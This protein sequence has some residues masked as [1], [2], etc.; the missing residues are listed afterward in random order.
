MSVSKTNIQGTHT[1]DDLPLSN[2]KTFHGW[3]TRWP[4]NNHKHKPG[5]TGIVITRRKADLR[6]TDTIYQDWYTPKRVYS[7]CIGPGL[8]LKDWGWYKSPWSAWSPGNGGKHISAGPV[9]PAR[10]LCHSIPFLVRK[11]V[12]SAQKWMTTTMSSK[13][14]MTAL[15]LSD[16]FPIW[17]SKQFTINDQINQRMTL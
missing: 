4:A 15:K 13:G 17:Y 16:I 8:D 3:T 2:K 7:L 6:S 14:Y 1:S 12:T 9:A 11:D 10:P 5:E